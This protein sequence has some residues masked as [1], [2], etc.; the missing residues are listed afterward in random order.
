METG[1]P[2]YQHFIP[3]FLLRN[4]SH[5]YV[6]PDK[7]SG[8]KP[9]KRNKKNR[10]YPGDPVINSLCLSDQYRIDECLVR[11]VCG[12]ENMYV[13]NTKPAKEQG[14]LE[15]SFGVLENRASFVYRKIT[16]GFE[17]GRPGIWLKRGEKDILRKFIFLLAY[18]GEQ[19]HR[20]YN[21][22]SMQDY[23]EDDKELL[24]DY[25][26]RHGFTRPIDVWLRSLETIVDLDMDAK[27]SW[28]KSIFKS[29]YFPIADAFVSHIGGMYMA[30]CTPANPDEEFVLADNCYNV[31]EGPTTSYYDETSGRYMTR[32]PRFHMFAPISPRLML[33]LR[34][35]LLPEPNHDSDPERKEY[36]EFQRRLNIDIL[37][38]SGTTSML[39]DLPIEKATNNYSH[40]ANGI[41]TPNPG[42]NHRFAMNDE[43]HFAIFK[44][45]THHVHK[46]NGLLIDHAFHGSRIV[47][48]R[49]D[50]FLD[51]LEWYLTEPC[52]VGKNL[53]GE[54]A[55]RQLAY[56]KGLSQFMLR[57][58]R[59]VVAEWAYW[60]S[61]H[62]DLQQFHTRNVAGAR[63]LEEVM[64][65]EKDASFGFDDIYERLGGT[66]EAF[67]YNNN[68][69]MIV[70]EIWA[71]CVDLDCE[72]P[73]YETLRTKKLDWLL[74][75]PSCVR[76]WMF[77]K[78]MRLAQS[79]G[80]PRWGAEA[81]HDISFFENCCRGPEDMLAYSY[82]VVQ[83]R[84][85][86]IAMYKAF[87]ESM[88][89]IR[90]PGRGVESMGHFDLFDDPSWRI[91]TPMPI[92]HWPWNKEIVSD[93]TDCGEAQLA[94]LVFDLERK[95]STNR[96]QRTQRSGEAGA[97]KI[98]VGG[99]KEAERS[100][101]HRDTDTETPKKAV[102]EV[103]PNDDKE[104]QE[105]PDALKKAARSWFLDKQ[106]N[107]TPAITTK[108]EAPQPVGK[109]GAQETPDANQQVHPEQPLN[110]THRAPRPW[111]SHLRKM[112]EAYGNV[113]THRILEMAVGIGFCIM[114]ASL[115]LWL[116][117]S[118]AQSL[119]RFFRTAAQLLEGLAWLLDVCSPVVF[120]PAKY[121]FYIG[122]GLWCPFGIILVY[123]HR[124]APRQRRAI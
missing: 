106:D 47:F 112:R 26:T 30:I 80:T 36:R 95:A 72:S 116:L 104:S 44:I 54:H 67:V 62:R 2:Q 9:K 50:V 13:D 100:R 20:R 8:G 32:S 68:M 17:E 53:M 45:P 38:G 93:G 43:F 90:G 25:M 101:I 63:F 15:K 4:F 34:H 22:D 11:R 115:H 123:I 23:H 12:L 33:V 19:Y 99:Q 56:I 122:F 89:L 42:W 78:R 81:I 110:E 77:L 10:M 28:K 96:R 117:G 41:W 61:E 1:K 51:L 16:K 3:Q 111:D 66:E 27:E 58:G 48:N 86:K 64:H 39:E 76:F 75:W 121:L 40:F 113:S 52:N 60:P 14:K 57:E 118:F 105:V 31:T 108:C 98:N 88:D 119:S 124:R 35:N 79:Q 87:I 59:A 103:R 55:V 7:A 82:P 65:G 70:F 114:F 5:K 49:K 6:P 71:R 97:A 46:M 29:V 91:P 109:Q 102:E 107:E 69:S 74:G 73:E 83:G 92:E 85:L 120:T 84:E 37:Y 21:L 18:R 24:Q 94:L